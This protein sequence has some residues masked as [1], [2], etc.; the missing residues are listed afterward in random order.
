MGRFQIYTDKMKE[1]G[2]ER[3]ERARE[4]FKKTYADYKADRG[5]YSLAVAR[6]GRI[7]E[8][9][10]AIAHLEA[11]RHMGY[12][13]D[14]AYDIRSLWGL[15]DD[16]Y[17]IVA[18]TLSG[19]LKGYHLEDSDVPSKQEIEAVIAIESTKDNKKLLRTIMVITAVLI[20]LV[21]V[22]FFACRAYCNQGKDYQ[23]VSVTV[24]TLKLQPKRKLTGYDYTI[25]VNYNGKTY[26]L[27]RICGDYIEYVDKKD[28]DYISKEKLDLLY[29]AYMSKEEIQVCMYKDKMYLT[30]TGMD[31]DRTSAKIRKLSLKAFVTL[32]AILVGEGIAYTVIAIKGRRKN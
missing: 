9:C 2:F 19:D 1:L 8:L 32:P 11:S 29:N 10:A 13:D 26:P 15:T 6:K 17:R 12:E 4:T 21:A 27:E 24:E 7:E 14:Q 25:N 31:H 18:E 28:V 16:E 5:L 20:V 23:K 22:I 3:S 30:E